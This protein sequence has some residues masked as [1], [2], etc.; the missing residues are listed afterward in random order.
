MPRILHQPKDYPTLNPEAP[1]E[2]WDRNKCVPKRNNVRRVDKIVFL[3]RLALILHATHQR[4]FT[5]KE[6]ERIWDDAIRGLY[7]NVTVDDLINE[8]VMSNGVIIKASST[9]YTL[10]HLSYQ[11]YLAA[12][13]ILNC[14]KEAQLLK[15]FQNRWWR[16]VIVFYSGLRSDISSLLEK[17]QMKHGLDSNDGLLEEMMEEARF[18]KPVIRDVIRDLGDDSELM[19]NS[20][21][22]EPFTDEELDTFVNFEQDELDTDLIHEQAMDDAEKRYR[23]HFE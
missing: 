3:S 6:V 4:E 21:G 17:I 22:V 23:R 18:T 13:A 8:L 19:F 11:E 9:T 10:G 5:R 12:L 7:P 2:D 14:Q 16:E 15:C 1:L 20:A